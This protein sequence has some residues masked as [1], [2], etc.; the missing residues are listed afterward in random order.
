MFESIRVRNFRS[1]EDS[2]LL[3][4][5]DLNIIVGPN[6]S[7][8]SSCL[9]YPLLM[10]KQTMEDP[11]P[12]QALITSGSHI[13][14]GSYLNLIHR[15][16]PDAHLAIRF[17]VKKSLLPQEV[18]RINFAEDS[19]RRITPPPV[20]SFSATFH[21]DRDKN[22]IVIREF[23]SLTEKGRTAFAGTCENAQWR[24]EGLPADMQEHV[25]PD[26]RHFLPVPAPSGKPPKND[27][28]R[29]QV[30]HLWEAWFVWISHLAA[31][32]GDIRY[33]TPIREA[34]PRHA[35]IGTMPSSELGP[36]GANLMRIMAEDRA[37]KGHLLK[38]LDEWLSNRFKL[39]GPVS[40]DFVDEA[41]TIVS[42]TAKARGNNNV[43]INLAD[44]GIGVS[45]LVPVIV[46][47]VL[48]PPQGCLLVEQ[49]EI[50]LHPGAQADLADLFIDALGE[51]R[52]FIIETH[53]E[54]LVLRVR[55]R[56]A[57]GKLDASRVRIFFVQL[58]AGKTHVRQ[59]R[60]DEHGHFPK[61]PKNF[62]EEGFE[63]AMAIAEAQ[64]R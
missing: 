58:R 12:G 4:L 1:V 31:L 49:P 18:L 36:K 15:H 53:S 40:L 61:W 28:L 42:L 55:R 13:D 32:I 39:T 16:Q 57:E 59:L 52:Q 63:E 26:L 24:T 9:I 21:F 33:V 48:L 8:K 44:M 64:I 11:E 62:F 19:G 22:Q 47:T 20:C 3:R 54:H 51:G 17:A 27:K 7:G 10:M 6:N 43:S 60:L 46:Q 30:L 56:I 37:G 25:Q 23:R 41:R 45:Q 5:A 2:G 38:R 34:I 35:L 50:H 14:L 29:R